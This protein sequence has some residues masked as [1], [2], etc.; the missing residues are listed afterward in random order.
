MFTTASVRYQICEGHAISIQKQG[1]PL[2]TLSPGKHC[3]IV[4]SKD[5]TTKQLIITGFWRTPHIVNSNLKHRRV[6]ALYSN[7]DVFF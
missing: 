3:W 2:K 1:V 5:S 7:T 4:F 6:E